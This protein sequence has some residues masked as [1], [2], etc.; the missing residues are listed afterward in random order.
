M[1]S[2]SGQSYS[3]KLDGTEVPYKNKMSADHVGE[4]RK[5]H[6]TPASAERG[7]L[8]ESLCARLNVYAAAAGAACVG[9]LTAA[10]PVSGQVVYTPV[11][12]VLGP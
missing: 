1:T 12:V 6:L 7:N 5:K 4:R 11:H 9:M 2:P 3:A 10:A 8:S